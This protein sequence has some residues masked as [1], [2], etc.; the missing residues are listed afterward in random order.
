MHRHFLVCI[1][2]IIYKEKNNDVKG[3]SLL[4]ID[5]LPSKGRHEW[6]VSTDCHEATVHGKKKNSSR[7]IECQ[8]TKS[9]WPFREYK[10]KNE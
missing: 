10:A 3:V 6:Q 4:R 9:L 2:K 1:I 7:D 8:N 5:F